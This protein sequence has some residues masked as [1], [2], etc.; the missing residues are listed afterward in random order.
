MKII[1]CV[2]TAL[3]ITGAVIGVAGLSAVI[4]VQQVAEYMKDHMNKQ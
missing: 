4:A 2:E 1:R 3:V